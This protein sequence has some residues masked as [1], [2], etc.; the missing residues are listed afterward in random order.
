M[1]PD[2]RGQAVFVLPKIIK[3]LFIQEQGYSEASMPT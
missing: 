2:A 3:S 1:C